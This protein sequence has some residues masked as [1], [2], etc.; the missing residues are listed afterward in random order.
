MPVPAE[1][2][3]IA[4]AAF[5]QGNLYRRLRDALGSIDADGLFVA[6]FPGRRQSASAPWR[7]APV[8]V[9]PCGD[10]LSDRHTAEAVRG[11]IAWE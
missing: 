2:A 10:G 3:R 1:T 11:R 7:L 9:M 5:P 4:R 8:T 6:L